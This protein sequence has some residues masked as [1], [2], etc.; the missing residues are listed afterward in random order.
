MLTSTGPGGQ[1]HWGDSAANNPTSATNSA[2]AQLKV[3]FYSF[4]FNNCF[5]FQDDIILGQWYLFIV[6]IFFSQHLFSRSFCLSIPFFIFNFSTVEAN[7]SFCTCIHCFSANTSWIYSICSKS[8]LQYS[9]KLGTSRH[10]LLVYMNYIAL[11]NYT[12]R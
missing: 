5:I 8:L 12:Q 10:A 9:R 7:L 1:T 4:I 6:V 11:L 2:D 3:S